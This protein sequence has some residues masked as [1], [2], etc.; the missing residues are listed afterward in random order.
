M[1]N[2][3]ESQ[4]PDELQ[5]AARQLRAAKR[6]PTADEL[7]R[8]K[9]AMPQRT[10]GLALGGAGMRGRLVTAALTL[11]LIGG[12]GGAVIAASG[13]GAEKGLDPGA[14]AAQQQY[15]PPKSPGA[16]KPKP[17]GGNCGEGQGG[18]KSQGGGKG[19]GKGKGNEGVAGL[20]GDRNDN[21]AG[22]GGASGSGS[23]DGTGSSDTTDGD[24]SGLPFTGLSVLA[25]LLAG[26]VLAGSGAVSRRRLRKR[27]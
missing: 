1:S 18:G 7:E 25:L 21:G 11:A 12:G 13:G 20:I 6:Q 17:P 4:L 16:G 10:G 24:G 14:S 19:K 2:L 5:D 22:V 26:A 3:D 27:P 15:C 23:G 9:P 8:L